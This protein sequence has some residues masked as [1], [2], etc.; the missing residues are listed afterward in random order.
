MQ[1]SLWELCVLRC[2]AG[3][4]SE[5]CDRQA[6]SLEGALLAKG[7]PGLASVCSLVVPPGDL[8]SH[9]SHK[10]GE[11]P[12]TSRFVPSAFRGE[13]TGQ[14][15]LCEVTS[16]GKNQMLRPEMPGLSAWWKVKVLWSQF[17][18]CACS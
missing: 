12:G 9:Q 6:S 17:Q 13:M 1:A 14:G 15:H 7:S 8:L 10:G 11:L 2:G 5:P 18:F 16:D 4:L 3:S